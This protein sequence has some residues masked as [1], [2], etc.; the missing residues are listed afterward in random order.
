[1]FG[2]LCCH[3]CR[4][5]PV[6]CQI[7]DR[8]ARPGGAHSVDVSYPEEPQPPTYRATDADIIEAAPAPSA[9]PEDSAWRRPAGDSDSGDSGWRP[10]AGDSDWRP[11]AGDSGWRGPAGDSGWRL[12]A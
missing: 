1:M 12:T 2:R 11:P 4:R 3:W 9:D 8:Q 5:V 6:A 10:Q 7:R